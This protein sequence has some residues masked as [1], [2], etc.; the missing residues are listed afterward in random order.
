M[1]NNEGTSDAMDKTKQLKV[2]QVTLKSKFG[3]L[4]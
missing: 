4:N 1:W 2:L 3:G